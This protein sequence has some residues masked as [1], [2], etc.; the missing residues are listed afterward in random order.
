MLSVHWM[1]NK[2]SFKTVIWVS[3]KQ[4]VFRNIYLT[5]SQIVYSKQEIIGKDSN[6]FIKSL[7]VGV[8]YFVLINAITP[9]LGDPPNSDRL[10]HN[11]TDILNGLD[12]I[13]QLKPQKY[14]KLKEWTTSIPGIIL[15]RSKIY[16]PRRSG[17]Q[18]FKLLW[19]WRR[20]LWCS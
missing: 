17:N 19:V 20:L 16:R 12:L 2:T 14:Q 5:T 7:T 11:E 1:R 6:F 10:K 13:R 8:S 15:R 9:T 3:T 4:G 18:Q